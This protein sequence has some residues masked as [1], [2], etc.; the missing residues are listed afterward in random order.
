MGPKQNT[1]SGARP[2]S[3]PVRRR[4]EQI[5]QGLKAGGEVDEIVYGTPDA[6]RGAQAFEAK[7][8]ER[9]QGKGNERGTKRSP[10][11]LPKIPRK[12]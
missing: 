7:A 8:L 2:G 10:A 4:L 5:G 12:T 1:G 6:V 9:A 3:S 11:N